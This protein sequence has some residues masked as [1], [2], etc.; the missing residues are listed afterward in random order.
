[1]KMKSLS[2]S[3]QGYRYLSVRLHSELPVTY[4][5]FKDAVTHGLLEWLGESEYALANISIVKNLWDPSAGLLESRLPSSHA[6]GGI[7]IIRCSRKYVE[8]VKLGLALV[9]QIGDSR[10][11][12]QTVRVSGT[13]AS[14]KKKVR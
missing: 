9:H 7:A 13:I 5:S 2:V 6:S 10:I 11:I 14:A 12:L 3:R 4:Q 1:M 8:K